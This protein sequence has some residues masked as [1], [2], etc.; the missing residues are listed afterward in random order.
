[1][2]VELNKFQHI[3]WKYAELYPKNFYN[4]GLSFHLSSHLQKEL[5][6]QACTYLVQSVDSLHAILVQEN[7]KLWLETQNSTKI[8]YQLAEGTQSIDICESDMQTFTRKNFDLFTEHPIRFKLYELTDNSFMFVIVFHHICIDGISVIDLLNLLALIYDSLLEKGE[9]PELEIASM[10]DGE[11]AMQAMNIPTRFKAALDY[12]HPILNM[13]SQSLHLID[14]NTTLAEKNYEFDYE[15]FQIEAIL[16]K[17]IQHLAKQNTTTPF[18]IILSAWMLIMNRLTGQ[19]II[20][21]DTAINLRPAKLHN[22]IGFFVNNL[23]MFLSFSNQMNGVEMFN[24]LTLQRK[25]LK[26]VQQ[27]SFP[28]IAVALKEKKQTNILGNTNVGINFVGWSDSLR[29]PFENVNC[30]FYKRLDNFSTFDLLLE[31]DPTSGYARICYNKAL[32]RSFI[33]ILISSFLNVLNT[34]VQNPTIPLSKVQLCSKDQI[35]NTKAEIT[36]RL[37]SIPSISTSINEVFESIVHK[38]PQRTALVYNKQRLS[39]ENLLM[40]SKTYAQNIRYQYQ[41]QFHK[42][43]DLGTP[44]GI[45]TTNKMQAIIW[46]FSILRAGGSYVFLPTDYPIQRLQFWVDDYHIPCILLGEGGKII[47]QLKNVFICTPNSKTIESSPLPTVKPNTTAYIISTSGTTGQPK[48]VPI[49]HKQ[50]ILLSQSE[51]GF[52]NR[53]YTMLQYASLTFDASVWELFTGLLHGNTVV[54]ATDEE[55]LSPT[56]LSQLIEKESVSLALLPPVLLQTIQDETPYKLT[57]LKTLCV[58]GDA[59]PERVIRYWQKGRQLY[60]LYG[61]TEA[62]VVATA[63]ETNETTRANDIGKPL[64]SVSIYILDTHLNIQP[65]F[66]KGELYLGGPQ[67]TSGYINRSELNASKFIQNPY[68]SDMDRELGQNLMLYK[69]GDIVSRQPNGHILFHGRCDYQV[70]VHGFR[71]ELGEIENQLNQLSNVLRA[72]V[73]LRTID[74][75][76]QIVAYV[77]LRSG[78]SNASATSLRKDLEKYLPY[79]MIPA[80]WSFVE[81]F[82]MTT[83]GKI[84]LKLLP[85]PEIAK[86]NNLSIKP[87]TSDEQLLTAIVNSVLGTNNISIDTDLFNLGLT[88]IQVMIIVSQASSLGLE[89]SASAFYRYRTIQAIANHKEASLCFWHS[90][91]ENKPI[92]IIVCGDTHFA[93][94]YLNVANRLAETY[95]VLVLESY[96]EYQ[97]TVP[98]ESLIQVYK[99][100]VNQ[101]LNGRE[102]ELICGFCIGGEIALSIASLLVK[103]ASAPHLL[104]L[105]S[106]ANRNK[107]LPVAMDYP[108]ISIAMAA[109]YQEETNTLL[110]TEQLPDYS[111]DIHIVLANQFTTERMQADENLC[112]NLLQQFEGNATEWKRRYPQCTI[113]W[114]EAQHW[115]LLSRYSPNLTNKIKNNI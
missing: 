67:L 30:K 107:L 80:V 32:E 56:L 82:P 48:G 39:F 45:S 99:T 69:T 97:H 43:L 64:N 12:W 33:K 21:I 74:D 61:P 1:M 93:P 40:L 101:I 103:N 27:F 109:R 73:V 25:Q 6:H 52:K 113:E 5:L 102:P 89:L 50:I 70:K 26:K 106:F 110:Q 42:E 65:D 4:L 38:Y 68:A 23:P 100:I 88:S 10:Q 16:M 29:I 57:P 90:W 79:Y 77:Q 95:S 60:N 14:D 63:C 66:F 28:E 44:I 24:L 11:K 36:A 91:Q 78:F 13:K 31:V 55:R 53:Q 84:D 76:S 46:I 41:S 59:T 17:E 92:A 22:L 94:D 85:A 34:L 71:I 2:K 112:S 86:D 18:L 105:D 3:L 104:L 7:G 87:T 81:S 15:S 111:G 83:N 19:E 35:E 8:D 96:H 75:E 49:S 98:W 72:V 115:N 114:V 37:K 51:A 58:G 20:F 62:T 47:T 108:G 54:C 9:Y